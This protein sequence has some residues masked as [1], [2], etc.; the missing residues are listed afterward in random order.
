MTNGRSQQ[1]DMVGMFNVI[2]ICEYYNPEH[3]TNIISLK[4]VE[5]IPGARTTMDTWQEREIF[6][7]LRNGNT[8]N[9]KEF[10]EGLYFLTLTGTTKPNINSIANY[11]KSHYSLLN[12]I[13]KNKHI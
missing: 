3:F 1:Y 9:F 2:T 5:L 4:Y 10:I 7:Q 6:V 12:I 11:S 8:M 13:A